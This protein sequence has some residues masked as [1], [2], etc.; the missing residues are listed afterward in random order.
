[1][2]WNYYCTIAPEKKKENETKFQ[3]EFQQIAFVVMWIA[4]DV[5]IRI[6][7]LKMGK[8]K[9]ETSKDA[10]RTYRQIHK[11]LLKCIL[12]IL[13]P[14]NCWMHFDILRRVQSAYC[15]LWFVNRF[16]AERNFHPD[17][18]RPFFFSSAKWDKN[19]MPRR[20]SDSSVF[21]QWSKR[22]LSESFFFFHLFV[23]SIQ[24]HT[25]NTVSTTQYIL[26]RI[27]TDGETDRR[28]H[29]SENNLFFAAH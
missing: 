25:A 13:I 28:L 4:S 23:F 27:A 22:R 29:W 16:E 12:I 21:L 10:K 7:S 5:M 18:M 11:C 6:H 14:G 24:L 17:E 8:L 3:N 19:R 9:C 26:I 15:T 20:F 1:M 2:R